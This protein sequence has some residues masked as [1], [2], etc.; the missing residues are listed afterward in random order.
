MADKAGGKALAGFNF[1]A[2][3]QI[4][5]DHVKYEEDSRKS[6]P[7]HWGFLKT[8]YRDLVKDDFP[9]TEREKIILPPPLALPPITPISRY[10]KIGRSPAVPETTAQFVGWR[11]TKYDCRLEKYGRYAKPK[12]GLV[13]QLNWPQEGID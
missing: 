2:Q 5:K 8:T 1:V 10:I 12:G 7:Q 3:D 6:W 4:W 11:S 13:R 9:K